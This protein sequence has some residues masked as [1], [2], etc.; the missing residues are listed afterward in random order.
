LRDGAA[1]PFG[2]CIAPKDGKEGHPKAPSK[3]PLS[4]DAEL[5]C[6]PAALCTGIG[7]GEARF[8][9][10]EASNSPITEPDFRA[11]IG[12]LFELGIGAQQ[13]ALIIGAIMI[14]T[15]AVMQTAF[16]EVERLWWTR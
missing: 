14:L 10:P 1:N 9:G 13:R 15:E 11:A 7:G 16:E 8:Y 5:I 6:S 4:P 12:T 2:T 3:S